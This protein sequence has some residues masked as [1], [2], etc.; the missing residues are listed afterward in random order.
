MVT[1]GIASTKMNSSLGS[2]MCRA[3]PIEDDEQ[4]FFFVEAM[5]TITIEGLDFGCNVQSK[6]TFRRFFFPPGH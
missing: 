1:V 6:I 4:W 5:P 3:E 2:L